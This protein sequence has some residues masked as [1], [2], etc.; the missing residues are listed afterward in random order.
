MAALLHGHDV[1]VHASRR[2]TFGMTVV[3]AV[4]TGMPVLVARSHGPAET[5]DGHRGRWPGML[6]EPTDDPAAIAAAYT[7][8]CAGPRRPGP[9]RAPG[10]S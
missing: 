2:E 3:E 9:G 10:P 6:F 7:K 8:L 1:L 5:L 4:A